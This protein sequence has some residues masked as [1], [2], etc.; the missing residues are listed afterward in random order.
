MSVGQ[1][2]SFAIN[3][4]DLT[5]VSVIIGESNVNANLVLGLLQAGAFVGLLEN[6][7]CMMKL[8]NG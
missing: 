8:K 6:D 5:H 7:F 2:E 4:V 3:V 1:A